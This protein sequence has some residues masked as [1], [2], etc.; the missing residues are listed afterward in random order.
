VAI[1]PTTGTQM[2]KGKPAL[3]A[4]DMAAIQSWI[5]GDAADN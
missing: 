3:S 1:P 4:A 2:S 5:C